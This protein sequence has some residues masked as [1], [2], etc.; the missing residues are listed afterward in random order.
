MFFLWKIPFFYA[1]FKTELEEKM[2]VVSYSDFFA[3]PAKFKDSASRY[4]LKVL[5]QEKQKKISRR[6]QKKLDSLNAA[7]GLIPNEIDAEKILAARKTEKSGV[8]F[9][10]VRF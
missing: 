5:P 8:Q 4:G 10:N 2:I 1:I 9:S 6:I 7:A 3:N